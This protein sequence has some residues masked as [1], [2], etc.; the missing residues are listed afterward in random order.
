[1]DPSAKNNVSQSGG[2]TWEISP[3]LCFSDIGLGAVIAF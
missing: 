2:K 3:E 1:M